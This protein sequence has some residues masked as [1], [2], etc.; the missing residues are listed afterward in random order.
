MSM[1]IAIGSNMFDTLAYANKL[2]AAGVEPKIAEVQAELQAELLS[3]LAQNTLATKAD[4]NCLKA[5]INS[6]RADMLALKNEL[7][8][9]LGGMLAGCTVLLATLS[10][11]FTHVR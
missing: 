11:F 10:A 4:I 7:L 9:K 6:I 5:D 3:E 2:K 1:S 8:V